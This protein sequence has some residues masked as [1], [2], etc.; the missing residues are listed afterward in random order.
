VPL[1][2]SYHISR[3]GSLLQTSE[4][5][6]SIAADPRGLLHMWEEPQKHRR[7]II[8]CD[9]T[10][11]QTGWNRSVRREGDHKIDNCA[12]EV[13]AV[14]ALRVFA[15]DENGKAL[16]DEETKAPKWFY[17]DKQVAEFFAP[18]DPV[19][20]ARVCDVVGRLYCG[21]AD[22]HGELIF[23][24]YPGPGVLTGQELLRLNYSNLWRWET[25]AGTQAE[26]TNAV[27]WRSW[28]Q[29]Q[30]LLW[31]RARRHL[32]SRRALI[33][34]AWLL[35]EYSN[36]VL[37]PN[38]MRARAAYGV[39]DDLLQAANMCYWAGHKWTYDVDREWEPVQEHKDTE[40]Q[41]FAP[42]LDDYAG[43][44]RERWGVA[45]DSWLD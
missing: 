32:L 37:D 14:D 22:V 18:I 4:S 13:F 20:A 5:E 21:D 1:L 35:A 38:T 45:V 26:E 2:A 7:Y 19:E 10:F 24:G 25:I 6:E 9:P 11:G 30:L 12:I 33:R 40:A 31:Q 23:E 29:S 17:Q 34:S 44:T 36:A 28:Q 39:H 3:S 15:R 41:R 42:T 27:G 16:I 43:S 8:G